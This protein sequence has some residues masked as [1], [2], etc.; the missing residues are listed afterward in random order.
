MTA[1]RPLEDILKRTSDADF[2]FL[3]LDPTTEK[4]TPKGPAPD[5]YLH[6]SNDPTRHVQR[7]GRPKPV[8]FA[9]TAAA[10]T[11]LAQAGYIT[12]PLTTL[13]ADKM[14]AVVAYRDNEKGRTLY[15]A[16]TS[17]LTAH[18]KSLDLH[19]EHL[20]SVNGRRSILAEA[21]ETGIPRHTLA[22]TY[23]VYDCQVGAMLKAPAAQKDNGKNAD[24]A[25]A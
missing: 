18:K 6:T 5:G 21:T 12:T 8:S 3:S 1:T 2:L 7:S 24:Q 14:D 4:S 13:R 20:S 11:S 23:G 10:T 17:A 22:V 19:R 15:E 25:E 16:F 9:S